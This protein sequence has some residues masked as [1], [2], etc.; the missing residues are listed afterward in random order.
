MIIGDTEVKDLFEPYKVGY[1]MDD[2][3]HLSLAYFTDFR[4]NRDTACDL[5]Q[6]AVDTVYEELNGKKITF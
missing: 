5:N 4:I 3:C 1:G 6:R 2:C